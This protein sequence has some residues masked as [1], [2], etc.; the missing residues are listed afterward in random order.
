MNHSVSA[1]GNKSRSVLS[2]GMGALLLA[3]ASGAAY[4]QSWPAVLDAARKEGSVMLYTQ[5]VPPLVERIKADFAKA[6][7]GIT[8]ETTRFAGTTVISKLDQ[9]RQGGMDGGDV[10]VTVEILWLEERVK[11]GNLRK[12]AGPAAQAWPSRYLLRDTIPVLA[13]EPL[14]MAYNTN[15]VKAPMTGYQDLLRPELKGRIGTT[16]VQ[17]ISIVA[18]YEW[19]EKTQGGDFLARLAAQAPRIYTGAVPNAQS[20]ASGEIAATAFSVP[21]VVMPLIEKGAPMKMVIPKP[22]LGIRYAGAIIGGTKRPNA[23]QVLL[24]YLMSP[25]GQGVWHGSGDSASPLPNI[26]G[27]PDVNSIQPFDPSVYNS[28]SVIEYKKKW[29]AMLKR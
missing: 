25:R 24:D 18:W 11:E 5:Q 8:L 20:T 1:N 16:E 3:M 6:Y 2:A 15:V 21:T 26:P 14:V 17:A 13:L 9:E 19:L 28:G 10:V 7:P 27:S 29:D 12:P 22:A 4:S 23:A